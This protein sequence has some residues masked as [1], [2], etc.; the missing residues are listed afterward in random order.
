MLNELHGMASAR[1]SLLLLGA[2]IF[3]ILLPDDAFP[4][5][6]PDPRLRDSSFGDMVQH[7]HRFPASS[8]DLEEGV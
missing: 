7:S 2:G 5:L 1:A 4:I 8:K 3:P 6:L